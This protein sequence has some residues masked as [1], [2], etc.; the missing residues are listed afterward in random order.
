ML[1][2]GKEE[3]GTFGGFGSFWLLRLRFCECGPFLSGISGSG[4]DGVV[5]ICFGGMKST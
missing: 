3:D 2:G 5:P 1:Q 4:L